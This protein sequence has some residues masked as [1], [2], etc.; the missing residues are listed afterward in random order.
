MHLDIKKWLHI[1][2]INGIFG[3]IELHYFFVG[4]SWYSAYCCGS[5]TQSCSTLCNSMDYSMPGLPVPH[6]L[7]KFTQ[8]HVHCISD[9]TQP[10]HPLAPSFTSALNLSQHQ[11]LFQWVSCS[12]EMTKI[13]S[14]SFSISFSNN[15]SR[16]ISL[17]IDWF[18]LLAVQASVRSLL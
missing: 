14:F 1:F 16:L 5:V 10:S 12:H 15:Y 3:D 17:K 4:H 7:P 18:D 13:Q 6:H 9:A 2:L 8:V 11:G